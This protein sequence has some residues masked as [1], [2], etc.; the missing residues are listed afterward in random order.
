MPRAPRTSRL[1]EGSPAMTQSAVSG[2]TATSSRTPSWLARRS[3][4]TIATCTDPAR[5][6]RPAITASSAVITAATALFGAAAPNPR[7]TGPSAPKADPPMMVGSYGSSIWP[8]A[9]VSVWVMKRRRGPGR[10]PSRVAS[11]LAGA[12]SRTSAPAARSRSA[13]TAATSIS[14]PLGDG[15]RIRSEAS[16][17]QA[18]RSTSGNVGSG[19]L[20]PQV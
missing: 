9:I 10:P 18:S 19:M 12:T 20:A 11:T 6:A 4:V 15:M 8:G 1:P 13:I 5:L 7:R 2:T 16:A 14:W 17:R 3:L